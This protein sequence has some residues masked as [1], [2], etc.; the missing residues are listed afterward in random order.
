MFV[1]PYPKHICKLQAVDI[2]SLRTP[3]SPT[4]MLDARLAKLGTC[5]EAASCSSAGTSLLDT[6][7]S[8]RAEITDSTRVLSMISTDFVLLISW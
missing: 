8:A 7:T 3:C 5:V 1:F 4:G 6:Y 2:C